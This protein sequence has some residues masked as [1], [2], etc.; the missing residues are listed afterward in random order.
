MIAQ[1]LLKIRNSNSRIINKNTEDSASGN[2]FSNYM[3][4]FSNGMNRIRCTG[5][6]M[7]RG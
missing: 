2:H 6:Q 7:V 4:A 1:D 3:I 5:S